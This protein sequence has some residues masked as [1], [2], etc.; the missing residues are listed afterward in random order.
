VR[1][2]STF[3]A[4]SAASAVLLLLAIDSATDWH[5]Y[6]VWLAA[7]SL[8]TLGIYG[9]DKLLSKV[10]G[11]RVPEGLLHLLALL[12]GFA[13][14]WLGVALLHHKS[15]RRKHG[16]VW[17]VLCLSSAAHAAVVFLQALR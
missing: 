17:L 15:N 16:A 6:A 8:E 5:W 3:G 10:S 11:P 1:Y 4:I 14:A 7:W 9:L 2:Y 12:G 13:G